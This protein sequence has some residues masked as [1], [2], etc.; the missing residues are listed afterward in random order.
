MPFEI[1]EGRDLRPR[2]VTMGKGDQVMGEEYD[3][4]KYYYPPGKTEP[5]LKPVVEPEP[6]PQ[7]HE[8]KSSKSKTAKKK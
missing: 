6:E 7:E 3:P 4:S 5:E 8:E 1:I 2:L